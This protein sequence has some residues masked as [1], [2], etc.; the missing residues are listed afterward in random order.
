[1][2]LIDGVIEVWNK[3]SLDI[4]KSNEFEFQKEGK[5]M[6]HSCHILF[7]EFSENGKVLASGDSEGTIRIWNF[8]K[9]R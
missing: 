8:S 5:F 9:G 1:V 2:G 3:N 7:L 6:G 4:I